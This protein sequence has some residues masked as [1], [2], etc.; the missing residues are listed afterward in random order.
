[1]FLSNDETL[2]LNSRLFEIN[3]NTIK[4]IR[5]CTSDGTKQKKGGG[6]KTIV[7]EWCKVN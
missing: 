1:M 5:T 2:C 7:S 3:N 4:T 6:K